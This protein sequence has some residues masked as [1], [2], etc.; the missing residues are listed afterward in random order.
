MPDARQAEL[1]AAAGLSLDGHRLAELTAG[2][3]GEFD[4]AVFD[5]QEEGDGESGTHALHTVVLLA[6]AARGLPDFTLEPRSLLDRLLG[7]GLRFRGDRAFARR[8]VLRPAAGGEA[9][10]ARAFDTEAR[11][12]LADN[13]G[14]KLQ[15]PAATLTLHRD[16]VLVP[17]EGRPALIAEAVLLSSAQTRPHGC[18]ARRR[19]AGRGAAERRRRRGAIRVRR[20]WIL[21]LIAGCVGA[22]GRPVRRRRGR[23]G[24]VVVVGRPHATDPRRLA[25]RGRGARPAFDGPLPDGRGP[26]LVPPRELGSRRTGPGVQYPPCS[27]RST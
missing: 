9:A 3:A 10:L 21:G 26:R 2:R 18:A 8:Y 11:A 25:R 1:A 13:P 5:L 17:A 7:G 12:R 4:A 6:G 22:L 20:A 24:R 27:T 15:P 14:W 19:P 23:G 16:G